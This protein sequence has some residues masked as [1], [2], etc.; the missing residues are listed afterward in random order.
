MEPN[1]NKQ[2]NAQTQDQKPVGKAPEAGT[3]AQPNEAQMWDKVD[4]LF[5]VARNTFFQG[6]STFVEV[7]DSLIA[8]LQDMKENEVR[9]LGG[10]GAQKKNMKLED[11]DKPE[12]ETPTNPNL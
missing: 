12:E 7:L 6:N 3:S 5:T 8:T 9:P 1:Q 4:S 2:P 11:Q 10:L